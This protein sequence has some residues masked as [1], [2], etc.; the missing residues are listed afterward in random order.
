MTDSRFTARDKMRAAVTA[1][2]MSQ[3]QADDQIA[4]MAE[5]ALDYG[6]L[7][8]AEEKKGRLL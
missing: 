5:I 3:R 4:I 6:A 1:G 8:E 7:A 2:R